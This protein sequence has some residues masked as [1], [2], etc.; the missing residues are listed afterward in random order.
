MENT[1]KDKWFLYFAL[2]LAVLLVIAAGGRSRSGCGAR[3][4]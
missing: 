4:A 2:A 3:A 1:K